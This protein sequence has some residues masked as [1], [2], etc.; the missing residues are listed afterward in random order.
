MYAPPKPFRI[1]IPIQFVFEPVNAPPTTPVV[2]SPL[3]ALKPVLYI[4]WFLFGLFGLV[5][6]FH[7]AAPAINKGL[8]TLTC[9]QPLA[10]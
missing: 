4:V 3:Q 5:V 2:E 1:T 10:K 9:Q 7:A 8:D 6:F